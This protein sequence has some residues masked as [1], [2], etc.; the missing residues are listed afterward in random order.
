[1]PELHR[2]FEALHLEHIPPESHDCDS[3]GFFAFY[4]LLLYIE[5]KGD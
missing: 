3:A 1:M 4:D 2:S 5:R